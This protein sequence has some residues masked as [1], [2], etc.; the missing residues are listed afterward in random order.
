MDEINLATPI[1]K[2]YAKGLSAV[3]SHLG[4][5]DFRLH[6]QPTYD[7]AGARTGWQA[8]GSYISVTLVGNHGWTKEVFIHR[9]A[10]A[11]TVMD[12]LNT[13]NFTNKELR[14]HLMERVES[15]EDEQGNQPCAGT[16]S[17]P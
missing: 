6:R 2:E 9:D 7:A 1:Q 11:V 16:L 8:L 3:I 13:A 10:E 15:Y 12:Q 17:E 5:M 14:Q 4:M